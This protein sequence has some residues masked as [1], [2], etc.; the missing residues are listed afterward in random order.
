[1]L[2]EGNALKRIEKL[3]A[4]NDNEKIVPYLHSED[5]K[6]VEAAIAALAKV[7]D[8]TS[9]VTLIDSE[10]KDRRLFIANT[11][12]NMSVDGDYE[13]ARTYLLNRYSKEADEDVKAAIHKALESFAG[14]NVEAK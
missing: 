12:S 8:S 7:G 4:K 3:A 1:M 5:K 6:V 14:K 9:L 2:F 13:Y 11:I 10:D